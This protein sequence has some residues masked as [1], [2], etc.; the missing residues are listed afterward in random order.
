L[1]GG[2][3]LKKASRLFK[4]K[5]FTDV[6]RLLEPQVFRFRE[7]WLFYYLLGVS[8]LYTGDFG[9]AFSYLQRAHQLNKDESNIL[10][11]LAAVHLKRRELSEA[12][13]KW[14]NVLDIDNKNL[15]AKR[16]LKM[17]RKNPTE[18]FVT[19]FTNSKKFQALFPGVGFR[20]PYQ[21]PLIIALLVVVTGFYLEFPKIKEFLKASEEK[22]SP[23]VAEV[24]LEKE[25][26]LTEASGEY[27]YYYS[28]SE[29][30]EIFTRIK[31]YFQNYRDNLAQREINRILESNA[32]QLVKDKANII[33]GYINAPDFA[34]FKDSFSFKEVGEQPHLYRNCYVKWKGR[35][36]NLKITKEEI[37]FDFL[38]GYH[39]GKVLEGIIPATLNFAVSLEQGAPVEIL[40]KIVLDGKLKLEGITIYKLKP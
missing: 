29:I 26:R 34:T 23:K 37:S 14:L 16:A 22:R 12:I 11:G 1:W 28:D 5:R 20:I 40:G 4:S 36:S 10:L 9:G 35:I 32:S 27:R 17:V 21:I 24:N 33:A 25:E 38:V 3:E 15:K 7:N 2:K 30:R 19:E 18:A 31:N 8:C 13:M 39:E 6:I